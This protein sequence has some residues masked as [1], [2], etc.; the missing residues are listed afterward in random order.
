MTMPKSKVRVSMIQI[1]NLRKNMYLKTELFIE[2]NGVEISVTV[3]E[4][5]SG[6]TE[7]N[8]RV[9]GAT[10]KLMALA[11]FGMPM[12]MFMTVSG[13]RTKLLVVGSTST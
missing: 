3:T 12:V 2:D 9:I 13:K 4:F 7:Q 1:L 8:M 5:R 6:L 10:T 11:N